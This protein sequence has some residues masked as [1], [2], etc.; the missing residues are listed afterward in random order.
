[1]KSRFS[2]ARAA[3]RDSRS[4]ALAML[5][6]MIVSGS[7]VACGAE[8]PARPTRVVFI[9]IDTLRYDA[10]DDERMPATSALAERGQRFEN[11][12]AT[13]STTQPT[14]ASLFTGLHPWAHGVTRNGAV[15]DESMLTVAEHLRAAGFETHA[16]VGSFPLHEMFGFAQGF[17]TYDDEFDEPY[18]TQW[19]G[20]ETEAGM[21]FSLADSLTDR[22]LARIDASGGDRQFFWFHYFDCHD[23]YGDGG[24]DSG[25]NASDN[26]GESS[27]ELRIHRLL[28]LSEEKS[29]KLARTLERARRLYDRD[30]G[31]VD[32]ALSRLF[33]KLREDEARFDT[34]IVLTAD[35]GESFGEKGCLG[36]GNRVT[37]EQIQVPLVLVSPRLEPGVRQDL[38]SSIDVARTLLALAGVS[39]SGFGGRDLTLG[40][41]RGGE[42]LGMRREFAGVRIEQLT[43]GTRHRV[44]DTC[45]FTVRDGVILSGDGEMVFEE[46]DLARVITGDQADELRASFGALAVR[47]ESGADAEELLDPEVQES[48]RKL[49]YVR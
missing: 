46:D 31:D 30:V 43:D 20:R 3:A 42:V 49:G 44:R 25:D 14:H 39:V 45:F 38:A 28:T 33:R 21:F 48:L 40:P 36:H 23:P 12:F 37:R 17:D 29:P 7:L 27:K 22:G 47:L 35:H 24:G 19:E 1:M 16:V 8:E 18:L 2:S 9:T 34:H 10:F 26:G 15:L 4:P 6:A 11:F 41:A 5:V 32:R 13:T